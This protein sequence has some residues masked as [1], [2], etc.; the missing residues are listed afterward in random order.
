MFKRKKSKGEKKKK[1]R[2]KSRDEDGTGGSSDDAS[3]AQS[4][5]PQEVRDCVSDIVNKRV[6]QVL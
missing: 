6:I 2:K 3:D 5:I 4:K 1:K